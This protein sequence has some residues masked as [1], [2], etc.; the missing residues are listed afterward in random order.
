VDQLIP[1]LAVLLDTFVG[2]FR[3]EPFHTFR[4]AVVA[5]ILCPAPHTLAEV[6]QTAALFGRFPHDRLYSL[7]AGARWDWDE[8]GRL[9]L[10][11]L[12]SRLA[13][14]GCVWL[15]VDDTLC[16]KRGARVAL[17]GFFLD[18]VTSTKSRKNFR[19]GVNWVVLGVVLCLPWRPDR[20]VCLPILWRAYRKKG[21]A[22]HRKRTDLAADLARLAASWL[23]DRDCWLVADAAYAGRALLKDRPANLKVIGPL[24]WD[25]ALFAVPPPRQPGQRGASRKKGKRLP[26]PRQMIEDP[27]AYAAT[28]EAV[29]ILTQTPRLRL[30][31]VREVLWYHTAGPERLSVVLVR[32]PSGHWRDEALVATAAEVSAAFVVAGYCRRWSIEVAFF[33]SKQFLGLHDPQVWCEASVERAH[34]MAWFVLSLTVLW[35][36][37]AGEQADPVKRDRPWYRHKKAPTFT[38][39][40]GALRLQLLRA[41]ILGMSGEDEDPPTCP[42]ILLHWL[43]AVR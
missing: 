32:D 34:P 30:Q 33:E 21:L 39:V 24:R 36:A 6:W 43:A 20:F 13:P 19:F 9:L 8:I 1:S 3:T 7:F 11:R 26:T 5:W 22:G 15:V 41:V 18:A 16:H 23:P 12:L 42:E 38:D 27:V 14:Q 29:P 37:E 28:T 35:Y 17:G 2:C 31:V 25:A 4:A 40:L 10:G